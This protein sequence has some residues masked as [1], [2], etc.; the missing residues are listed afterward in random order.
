MSK[1][2]LLSILNSTISV[3]HPS[4]RH[5]QAYANQQNQQVDFFG[6]PLVDV[7]SQG[8]N[9]YGVQPQYTSYNPYMQ[10]PMQTGY[11][12]FL[13]QQ[14]QQEQMMQQQWAEQQRQLELQQQAQH[15]QHLMTQV[16]FSIATLYSSLQR[17]LPTF[18]SVPLIILFLTI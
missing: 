15:Y 13:Q 2:C 1:I 3:S 14:M 9:P 6:N 7:N 17:T 5:L 18:S 11:N 4:F 12:P 10:Q 8:Q 16:S